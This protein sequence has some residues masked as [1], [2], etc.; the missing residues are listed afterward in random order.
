MN[1]MDNQP[2][3]MLSTEVQQKHEDDEMINAKMSQ[4]VDSVNI[5]DSSY[6]KN[7]P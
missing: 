4:L 3:C 2:H 5:L 1:A 6:V 7:D